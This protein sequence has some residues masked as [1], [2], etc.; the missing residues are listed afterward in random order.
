M[1][2][3]RVAE[4]YASQTIVKSNE[5][6][7]G[8][9]KVTRLENQILAIAL[10]RIEYNARDVD[11]PLVARL[12]PGEL[13]HLVGSPEHIYRELKKVSQTMN[14]HTMFIEDGKGNFKSFAIVPNAEYM[15]GVFTV[16]INE[17]LRPHILNLKNNFTTLELSVL[18][19][20]TRVSSSRIYE[21]L[22]KE[23]YRLKTSDVVKVTYNLSEFKF[24][25]G[26][27]N[28]E[29]QGV[30][31]AMARMGKNVDWD[32]LYDIS[33]RDQKKYENWSNLKVRVLEPA[34]KEMEEKANIRFEYEGIRKGHK[35][36]ALL[37]YIYA[38][39]PREDVNNVILNK[40]EIMEAHEAEY[41]QLEV[42]RDLSED[43]RALYEEYLGHA[44]LL[45]KE[46]LDMLLKKA[47]YDAELVRRAIEK[48]DEQPDLRNYIGFLVRCI[49]KGGYEDKGTVYGDH[50]K[51][52]RYDEILKDAH[53]NKTIRVIWERTK[54]K[55]EFPVFLQYISDQGLDY[56][57]I[58]N[59]FDEEEKTKMFTNWKNGLELMEGI[60]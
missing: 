48:A 23:A 59:T 27:A 40:K 29:D 22:K 10:S 19:G 30:K 50:E 8:K 36:S 17:E 21:L 46:D 25:V 56:E 14:G 41:T 44:G 28:P 34:K 37:I 54:K 18:T 55:E 4:P 1:D 60:E 53:Q 35:I 33:P 24:M 11:A 26:L 20:F 51:A 47:G 13:K 38:N 15:D 9:Y 16:H 5:F 7:G 31:N 6:I 32:K 58:E 2:E 49:E 39:K 45:E 52:S 12:Y 3:L 57:L 42:P 43:T